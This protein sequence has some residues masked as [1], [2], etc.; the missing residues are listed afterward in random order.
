MGIIWRNTDIERQFRMF[1]IQTLWYESRIAPDK[2]F[3]QTALESDAI[4][5]FRY[6]DPQEFR[7]Q[8]TSI[9]QRLILTEHGQKYQGGARFTI[10]PVAL[11]KGKFVELPIYERIFK[12]DVLVIKS[13]AMRD[14]DILKKGF[15]DQ[16]F[17]FDVKTILSVTSISASGAEATHVYPEDYQ[18]EVNGVI[19]TYVKRD[20]VPFGSLPFGSFA[21]GGSGYGAIDIAV[22]GAT[23]IVNTIKIIWNTDSENIPADGVNYS[24]EFLCSPNYIV[25]DDVAQPR[26]TEE[27]DLPKTILCV[28]RAYY[29]PIKPT[30]DKV[31]TKDQVLDTDHTVYTDEY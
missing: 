11:S 6:N 16:L 18:L 12:G 4:H 30:L 2:R 7:L 10:P 23:Q 26:A 27:N 28:K 25:Y 22:N 5:G 29:N 24:V 17:A 21:F 15:R 19:A 9:S 13:K 14:Y 31:E 8:R 1:G 20:E 3:G